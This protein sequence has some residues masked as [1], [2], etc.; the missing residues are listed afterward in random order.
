MID[1]YSL[2]QDLELFFQDKLADK[3]ISLMINH[4]SNIKAPI[5]EK[6]FRQVLIN[7]IDNSIC[8]IGSNGKISIDTYTDKNFW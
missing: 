4:K 7:L 1:V 5:D 2:L 3:N 6:K 8:A